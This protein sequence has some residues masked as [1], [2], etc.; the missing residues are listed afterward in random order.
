M[1][2]LIDNQDQEALLTYRGNLKDTG[3]AGVSVV[4]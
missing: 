2:A 3:S 4:L 1:P